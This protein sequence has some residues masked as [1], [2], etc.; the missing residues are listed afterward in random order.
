MDKVLWL[1]AE[2][3]GT[4]RFFFESTKEKYQSLVVPVDSSATVLFNLPFKEN[5]NMPSLSSL[6][7]N[8]VRDAGFNYEI[9]SSG[10]DNVV[11]AKEAAWERGMN[12]EYWI[13]IAGRP[14]DFSL[15][16]LKAESEIYSAFP[17]VKSNQV[18]FCNTSFSGYFTEGVVEPDVMLKDL[19]FLTG[20]IT[21]HQPKYFKLL[22]EE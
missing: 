19:L 17:S 22:N 7:S 4:G 15:T 14:K 5:W 12:S 10:Q 8:L 3:A 21:D 1:S 2:Q 13:I 16:D 9:E 18:I 6:T 11:L 20:K